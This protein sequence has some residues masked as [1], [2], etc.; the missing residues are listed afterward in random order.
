MQSAC[1]HEGDSVSCSVDSMSV[2]YASFVGSKRSSDILDPCFRRWSNPRP[3]QLFSGRTQ[4]VTK[5][6]PITFHPL[7]SK[8]FLDHG[9]GMQPRGKPV[10]FQPQNNQV[11]FQR[12]SVVERLDRKNG[13]GVATTLRVSANPFRSSNPVTLDVQLLVTDSPHM[14]CLNN[15]REGSQSHASHDDVTSAEVKANGWNPNRGSS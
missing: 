11:S 10:P 1:T 4:P 2:A 14:A 12:L 9:A 5:F 8:A 6:A 13:A 7:L 3:T 15:S